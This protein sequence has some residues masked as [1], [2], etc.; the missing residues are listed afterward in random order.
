MNCP[1][2]WSVKPKYGSKNSRLGDYVPRNGLDKGFKIIYAGV[3][4]YGG[5]FRGLR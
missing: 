4:F 1:A 2:H 3:I 5:T